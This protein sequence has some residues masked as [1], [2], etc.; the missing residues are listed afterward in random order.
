MTK[1]EIQTIAQRIKTKGI[2]ETHTS[3]VLLTGEFAYKIK[4][5]VNF[6]FLDY[7]TKEKRKRFCWKEL[8]L[9]RRL[10]PEIY[11][12]VL[13]IDK[14]YQ[15]TAMDS[16]SVI[17]YAVKM[18]ELP[19]EVL[20]SALLERKK[21]K[22]SPMK[23]IAEIVA[24]FHNELK[25]KKE[26]EQY[27]RIE[28]IRFNWEENFSQ[29]E[30]FIG[31]TISRRRYET[32]KGKIY[33]FMEKNE[34][35]FKQRI[36]KRKIKFCHGDLHSGNIFILDRP[37]IFDCIEF[38]PRF[39]CCDTASEVAFFLMD[40]EF[41]NC[42]HLADY[43]LDN[44]LQLTKDFTLLRLISFYKAYRAYVRGKVISFRLKEK[45]I[46]KKD[47]LKAKNLAQR[48]FH[49]SERYVLSL[50]KKP[51]VLV[52]FG[53]P[54]SGKTTLAEKMRRRE[55]G[56]FLST[57]ILR[58]DLLGIPVEKHL[59]APFGK[60]IYQKGLTQKTYRA[61]LKRAKE[62]Y[63]EKMP[64]FLDGTFSNP[65]YRDLLKRGLK[66]S[67][68]WILCWAPRRVILCRLKRERR[69]SDAH[70]EIYLKMVRGYQPLSLKSL[71]LL[72]LNTKRK[73][74]ENIRK[75]FSWLKDA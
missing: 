49:Q 17:D 23:E 3:W 68:F 22:F 10:A 19:Q 50:F 21:V 56:I 14:D 27:G 13:G 66:S 26:I 75:I 65:Y 67:L 15:F 31:E 8:K 30:G 53:P 61:L 32:I 1:E 60:G 2:C 63:R 12:E 69:Y 74:R 52:F 64:I 45:G 43:F 73:V 48:Y 25:G 39:S 54:A 38:N 34:R 37:Y 36:E 9:N 46:R 41:H 20:M 11:L 28:V 35:L 40:L 42:H 6:G 4:K 24:N 51:K 55:E 62:Y 72:R 71:N 57:D 16:P 44:Y 70:P 33:S 59:P 18:K 47:K 5:P 29:T 7:T 58:K